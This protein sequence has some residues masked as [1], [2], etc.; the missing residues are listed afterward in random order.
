MNRI[1]IFLV[2]ICSGFGCFQERIEIDNNKDENKKIVITG[3]I[4]SLAEPQFVNVSRTVNYLGSIGIDQVSGALV[5]LTDESDSYAL[6][7]Q[8]AGVYHLPETWQGKIG[9]NYELTVTVEGKTYTAKEKM[10]ACPEIENLTY[11][12]DPDVGEIETEKI[13]VTSFDF[14][15]IVGE[16]DAY[17]GT[18]YVKGGLEGDSLFY[19]E[20]V[21]DEFSDGQYFEGIILG[22]GDNFELNDTVVVEIHS[23]GKAVSEYLQEIE[24]EIYR[25]GPFDPPP[26]NVKTNMEGGAIGY[27]IISDARKAEI[28]IE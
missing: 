23:I 3:W 27:F 16:G 13:Y 11:E 19:G 26:A 4:S 22:N 20:Y 15:E 17:Y 9:D 25:G 1:L 7:E 5:T 21:D 8:A 24:N 18:D 12:L 10:R 6:T 2:L 14:Q 28:V